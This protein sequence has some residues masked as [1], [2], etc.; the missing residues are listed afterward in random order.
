[1]IWKNITIKKHGFIH[2]SS[3]LR[4]DSDLCENYSSDLTSA[5]LLKD[6]LT[7]IFYLMEE[8]TS[9]LLNI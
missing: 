2:L 3:V 5:M 6:A 1:M 9:K 8:E 7:T 4:Y